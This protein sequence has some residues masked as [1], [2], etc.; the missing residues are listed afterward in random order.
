LKEGLL[1]TI[2]YFRK[3]LDRMKANSGDNSDVESILHDFYYLSASSLPTDET[4][5]I[6]KHSKAD[7]EPKGEL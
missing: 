6:E 2:N 1:K 7:Q 3:Q 5:S 4:S